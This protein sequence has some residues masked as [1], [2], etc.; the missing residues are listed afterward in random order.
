MKTLV[1]H[2]S[3]DQDAVASAWLAKRYMPEFADAE[4]K[5]VSA[6]KTLDDKKPDEDPDI[7]HV[8]TGLG[9]FDHHQLDDPTQQFSA[10]ERVFNYLKAEGHL[11]QHDVEPLQRMTD[12][13]TQIDHFKEVFYPDPTADRYDFMLRQIIDGMKINRMKDEDIVEVVFKCLDGIFLVIRQKIAAEGEINKGYIFESMWGK[14][15]AMDT[16]NEEAIKHALKSG[17]MLV[18]KREPDHGHIR[19]K[20]RPVPDIDLT[21]V[22]EILK[23]RDPKATWY[24][25]P[26]KHMLLNG[27]SKRPDSVASSLALPQVIEIIR[28]I[29]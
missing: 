7:I 12:H 17:Y 20:S 16:K 24:L 22:Y 15:I 29:S 21:P 23:T 2:I 4:I 27:S 1:T 14:T 11:K 25:H 26:S 28:S 3:V 8:D 19:I 10:T 9:Q 13:I 6:G 18:L 5:F